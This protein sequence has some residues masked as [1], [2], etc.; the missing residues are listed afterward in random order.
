M[1][2][3]FK[4]EILAR[5]INEV[6]KKWIFIIFVRCFS[7]RL[8][9]HFCWQLEKTET[10][11]HPPSIES[12]QSTRIQ[13]LVTDSAK[14]DQFIFWYFWI[15]KRESNFKLKGFRKAYALSASVYYICWTLAR[16]VTT[17]QSIVIVA[18]VFTYHLFVPSYLSTPQ[19]TCHTA[20]IIL[21]SILP[22]TSEC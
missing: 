10:F 22:Q 8:F 17:E 12:S 5:C 13:L 11:C 4:S 6:S 2:Q 18:N 9:P 1:N 7:T 20:I 3:F 16:P 19:G 21:F 14:F 15:E